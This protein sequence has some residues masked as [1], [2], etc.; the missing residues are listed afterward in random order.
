MPVFTNG[1]VNGTENSINRAV[2]RSPFSD[3]IFGA[4]PYGSGNPRVPR[5]G[6]Q[7]PPGDRRS[8]GRSGGRIRGSG[9]DR[10]R[11]RTGKRGDQEPGCSRTGAAGERTGRGCD[12]SIQARGSRGAREA[13]SGT[14]AAST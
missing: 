6:I 10:E 2:N 11:C 7:F 9:T 4:R 13:R 8:R 3:V 1:K 14:D 5:A 12:T